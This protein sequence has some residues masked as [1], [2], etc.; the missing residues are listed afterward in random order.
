ML[1]ALGL[2]FDRYDSRPD[3]PPAESI[4]GRGVFKASGRFA[5]SR[6]EVRIGSL[7][8]YQH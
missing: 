4:A 6:Q 8:A 1:L 2:G 7:R 3:M 5:D